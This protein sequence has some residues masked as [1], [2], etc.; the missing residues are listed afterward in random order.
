M[1][2]IPFLVFR[3]HPSLPG[4]HEV[5]LD[6]PPDVELA[7]ARR[8]RHA[9]DVGRLAAEGGSATFRPVALELHLEL[10]GGGPRGGGRV[11][12]GQSAPKNTYISLNF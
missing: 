12:A 5:L 7:L 6:V 4:G 3:K 9:H 8:P 10:V 11:A 1:T 2:Q